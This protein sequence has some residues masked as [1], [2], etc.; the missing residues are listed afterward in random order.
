MIFWC[1][2]PQNRNTP[3]SYA[4]LEN[5]GITCIDKDVFAADMFIDPAFKGKK[6]AVPMYLYLEIKL[7][8]DGVRYM[9]VMGLLRE[10][11]NIATKVE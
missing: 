6:L 11:L 1:L 4:D 3:I 5:L 7:E 9:Q 10:C 8:K 2:G